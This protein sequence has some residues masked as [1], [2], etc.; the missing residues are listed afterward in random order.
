[1]PPLHDPIP[2]ERFAGLI[3]EAEPSQKFAVLHDAWR[4]YAAKAVRPY[5]WKTFALYAR[6]HFM[7][8]LEKEEV[9]SERPQDHYVL[10][11]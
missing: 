8:V 11:E 9:W 5:A 3:C 7:D 10:P 1:M 2:Y 4:E 6:E